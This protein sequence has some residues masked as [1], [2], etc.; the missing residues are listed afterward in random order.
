MNQLGKNL[1]FTLCIV[2]TLLVILGLLV[3]INQISGTDQATAQEKKAPVKP[4]LEL[5]TQAYN[6]Y[7]AACHG[8]TGEGNGFNAKHLYVKP[9]NH[10]NAKFMSTR[11]DEKLYDVINMGGIG[12][13]KSTLM[14]PWGAAIGDVR[15][16]SLI[17]KLRDLCKCESN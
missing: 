16:Q 4:S 14:P 1:F 8:M 3:G 6:Y 15:I 13:S 9:A 12:I 11:T 5:G 7:C 17:L 2:V 10:A